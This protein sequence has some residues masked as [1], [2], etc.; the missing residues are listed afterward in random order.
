MHT[1]AGRAACWEAGC[2][3][4]RLLT[5]SARLPSNARRRE[6]YAKPLLQFYE[7]ST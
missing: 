3:T 5:C 6:L 4:G 1:H 2:A 7:V